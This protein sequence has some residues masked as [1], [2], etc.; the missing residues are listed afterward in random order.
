MFGD[1][2]EAAA[3]RSLELFA[4]EVMPRLADLANDPRD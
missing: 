4:T 1:I 2:S 3:R